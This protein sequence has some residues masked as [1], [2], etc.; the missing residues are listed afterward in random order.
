[1]KWITHEQSGLLEAKDESEWSYNS[2]KQTN[3]YS[4]YH[5]TSIQSQSSPTTAAAAAAAA[6][7]LVASCT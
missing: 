6:R 2:Q 1:M 4:S 3:T 7:Q 5:V